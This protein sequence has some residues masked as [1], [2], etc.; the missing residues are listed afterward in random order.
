MVKI[1]GEVLTM[2]G[3]S[4]SEILAELG[5]TKGRVAVECNGFI[6]PKSQY[7]SKTLSDGDKVEIVR[8]VG[9]G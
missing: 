5:Y 3:R 4:I 1:N 2:D 8:F 6:V 9:G 7:D